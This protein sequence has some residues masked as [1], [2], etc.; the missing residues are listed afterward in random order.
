MIPNMK[1]NKQFRQIRE[2]LG[3][4]QEDFAQQLGITR[5]RVRDYEGGKRARLP[6][7]IFLDANKLYNEKFGL[8]NG[9]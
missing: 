5:D 7:D 2:R 6:A 4:S 9:G 8:N 3:L 1:S